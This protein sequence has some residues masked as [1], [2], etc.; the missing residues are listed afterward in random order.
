MRQG[1]EGHGGDWR[2]CF[3]G[4]QEPWEG[5]EQGRGTQNKHPHTCGDKAGC[6]QYPSKFKRNQ[7]WPLPLFQS[8]WDIL[9]SPPL[10]ALKY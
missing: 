8:D 6:G 10:S 1:L 5:F 4:T 7:T 2:F 9:Q 3:R